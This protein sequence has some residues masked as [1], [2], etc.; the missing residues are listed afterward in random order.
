[1]ACGQPGHRRRDE[2][3]GQGDGMA[4]KWRVSEVRPGYQLCRQHSYLVI[5]GSG[6]PR[7]GVDGGLAGDAGFMH[8]IIGL[9]A[10][11]GSG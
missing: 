5:E 6:S 3:S 4:S 1:M 2:I 8:E 9:R 11:T 10:P 7:S